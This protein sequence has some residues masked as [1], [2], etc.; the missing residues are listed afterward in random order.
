MASNEM[1]HHPIHIA[2]NSAENMPYSLSQSKLEIKENTTRSI[3]GGSF[4]LLTSAIDDP[5]Q[6]RKTMVDFLHMISS[7]YYLAQAS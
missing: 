6:A 7:I 3:C 2:Y 5:V 4:I 1:F